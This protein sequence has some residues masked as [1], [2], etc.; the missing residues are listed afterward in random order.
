MVESA[1]LLALFGAMVLITSLYADDN[2]NAQLVLT[3]SAALLL[4]VAIGI[5]L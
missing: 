3:S 4:G 5:L 2:K 1:L